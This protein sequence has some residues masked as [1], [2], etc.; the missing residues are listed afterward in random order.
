MLYKYTIHEM[1]QIKI[2]INN[3]IIYLIIIK[4]SYSIIYKDKRNLLTMI[5]ITCPIVLSLNSCTCVGCGSITTWP[6][7]TK[8]QI[9]NYF[10]SNIIYVNTIHFDKYI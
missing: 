3:I 5:I 1:L 10:I 7:E 9:E 8:F 2:L 6:K 4:Q